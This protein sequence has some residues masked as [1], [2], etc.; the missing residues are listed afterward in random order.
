[1]SEFSNLM[2]KSSIR[3]VIVALRTPPLCVARAVQRMDASGHSFRELDVEDLH[4]LPY[5][6]LAECVT[7][8]SDNPAMEMT[9]A[10]GVWSVDAQRDATDIHTTDRQKTWFCDDIYSVYIFLPNPSRN[11]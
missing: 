1:M 8:S 9:C 2:S 3:E 7:Y 4:D 11:F 5:D 10:D 6:A